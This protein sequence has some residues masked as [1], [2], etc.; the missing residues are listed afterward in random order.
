M[1]YKEIIE[2]SSLD[3]SKL[4]IDKIDGHPSVTNNISVKH[5]N[6]I[7]GRVAINK[8]SD[9]THV[10]FIIKELL[11]NNCKSVLEIGTLWGGALITMMQSKYISM[12]VSIDPFNGYYKKD[13]G[14]RD[15]FGSI[16]PKVGKANSYDLV[17]EN[18][19]N[20]N[21]NQHKF[22]LLKGLST[23]KTIIDA[24][25]K[26]FADGID[27]LFIDGDHSL[28]GVLSDWNNYHNLINPGGIVVF[29]DYWSGNLAQYEWPDDFMNVVKAYEQISSS[30][31]FFNNWKEIGL[32]G[33]K[34]I[35][36][37]V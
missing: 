10:L 11:G 33:D 1:K 17:Y 34:K 3:Y 2:H 9:N 32:Y 29:D 8:N 4:I 26:I 24:V 14:K 5:I 20:N 31:E 37:K 12:F 27:L 15:G 6:P 25:S 22:K 36:Q 28:N 30:P 18:V 21:L 7:H 13:E 19:V 16:D 23:D 35:I